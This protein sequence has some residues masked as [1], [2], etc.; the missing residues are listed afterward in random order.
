MH[1]LNLDAHLINTKC[2]KCDRI[3][4]EAISRLR[5]SL[6]VSCLTCKQDFTVDESEFQQKVEKIKTNIEQLKQ[7]IN[8]KHYTIE[9]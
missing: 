3:I 6:T 8:K 1:N 7:S 4:T 5:S 2:P 9:P